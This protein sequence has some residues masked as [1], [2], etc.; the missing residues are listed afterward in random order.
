MEKFRTLTIDYYSGVGDLFN[1]F[2]RPDPV[3]TETLCDIYT[4]VGN[5]LTY[6]HL[7]SVHARIRARKYVVH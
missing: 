7:A 4:Q 5:T 2:I 1:T 6:I 3:S